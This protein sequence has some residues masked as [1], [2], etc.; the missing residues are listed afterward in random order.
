MLTACSPPRSTSRGRCARCR[1]L[2][3]LL[4][5]VTLAQA[6]D[7]WAAE[8]GPPAAGPL[9]RIADKPLTLETWPLWR[10]AY[11][12]VFAAEDGDRGKEREF[13]RTV[14]AFVRAAAAGSEGTLPFE[15]AG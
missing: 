9:S 14:Q 4:C 1:P 7:A 15:L 10:S 12:E 3:V 6:G 13:Y 11:V 8:E 5:V 2:V